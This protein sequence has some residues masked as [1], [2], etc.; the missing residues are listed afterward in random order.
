MV[1][2]GIEI[3]FSLWYWSF[4]IVDAMFILLEMKGFLF[5]DFD[6]FHGFGLFFSS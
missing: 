3:F 4:A 2:S 1:L 6:V 5:E